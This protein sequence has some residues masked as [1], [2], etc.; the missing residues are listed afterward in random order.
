MSTKSHNMLPKANK[1]PQETNV[2]Q[3]AST[4]SRQA[5][6]SMLKPTFQFMEGLV[7]N[8]MV[9]D[10]YILHLK[11]EAQVFENARSRVSC[12]ARYKKMHNISH[13]LW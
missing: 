11:L 13:M 4:A 5:A 1:Q 10:S 6:T 3:K 9:D 2:S 12:L 8:C 7:M